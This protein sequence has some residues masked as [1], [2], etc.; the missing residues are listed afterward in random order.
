MHVVVFGN[1]VQGRQCE[2][3]T[4]G[5]ENTLHTAETTIGMDQQSH[6]NNTV[7]CKKWQLEHC[8]A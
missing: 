8:A 5:M 3:E 7:P 1:S 2:G 4:T 6:T